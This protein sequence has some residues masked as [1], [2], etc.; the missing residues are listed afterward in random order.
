MFVRRVPRLGDRGV[1]VTTMTRPSKRYAF[2]SHYNSQSRVLFAYNLS[3]YL[4]KLYARGALYIGYVTRI[5]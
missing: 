2:V 4:T 1:A 5:G 3:V